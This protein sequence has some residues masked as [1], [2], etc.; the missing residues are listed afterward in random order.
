MLIAIIQLS[1]DLSQWKQE[2]NYFLDF[3]Q[4]NETNFYKKCS[5]HISHI[6]TI[7]VNLVQSKPLLS[8]HDF[9]EKTKKGFIKT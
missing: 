4:T 7:D 2:K 8:N 1:T 9:T 3:Q 5:L 6:A